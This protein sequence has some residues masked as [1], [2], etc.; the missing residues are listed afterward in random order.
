ML[1]QISY[2]ETGEFWITVSLLKCDW[3]IYVGVYI[4]T[5]KMT[6][7]FK[8]LSSFFKLQFKK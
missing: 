4:N 6:F 7:V 8:F 1:K 5:M 3:R 2:L